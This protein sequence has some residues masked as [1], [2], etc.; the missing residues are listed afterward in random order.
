MVNKLLIGV[1]I[2]ALVAVGSVGVWQLSGDDR[3]VGA[4]GPIEEPIALAWRGSWTAETKYEVGQVVSYK[5]SSYV[6]EAA[7]GGEVP[8]AKEGP[9][10]LMAA[11]GAQGAAGTFSGTF[12][13]PDGNYTLS[14]TNAGIEA[15]GPNNLA[16]TLNSSGVI[17]KSPNSLQLDSGG[18]LDLKA[19]ANAAL[20]G[21]LV[22]VGCA[23]GGSRVARHADVV[24]GQ[25]YGD[26]G[27]PLQNG[28]IL[29]GSQHV[30]AC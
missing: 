26:Y 4:L 27:G 7:N 18:T 25:V 10:A 11:Q 14:V 13:S 3:R 22:H 29:G 19:G 24:T 2:V 21:G 28:V 12:Q 17:V 20:R 30:F 15:R 1:G 9:W 16:V 5:G 8:N 23:S 6:A